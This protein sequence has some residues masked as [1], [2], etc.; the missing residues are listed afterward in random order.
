[1]DHA[2]EIRF[3][4]SAITRWVKWPLPASRAVGTFWHHT[5]GYTTV[6]GATQSQVVVTGWN[7]TTSTCYQNQ[8]GIIN[9]DAHGGAYPETARNTA[10]N[11][12]G[13]DLCMSIGTQTTT[14]AVDGFT[15]NGNQYDAPSDEVTWPNTTY[16]VNP[17][18]AVWLR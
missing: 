9:W 15:S 11:T 8:Y 6:N 4:N 2:T 12:Q 16:N 1:V 3:S 13:N 7:G 10:G 18:V 14:S 17:H 5:V